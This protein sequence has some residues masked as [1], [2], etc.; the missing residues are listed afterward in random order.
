MLPL[1]DGARQAPMVRSPPV[2]LTCPELN[3]P[4]GSP[5]G[6]PSCPPH[7]S[8]RLP[9]KSSVKV[10]CQP[11]RS[12]RGIATPEVPVGGGAPGA[13][14]AAEPDPLGAGI[15]SP[16][17]S[18]LAAATGAGAACGVGT[19][20]TMILNTTPSRP[21]TSSV[22]AT[23]PMTFPTD[24]RVGSG[25][26]GTGGT[27]TCGTI[28]LAGGGW[29]RPTGAYGW[30]GWAGWSGRGGWKGWARPTGAGCCGSGRRGYMHFLAGGDQ[31]GTP[32]A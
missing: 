28:R 30:G 8:V 25:G 17:A 24:R 27:P 26:S 31:R 6:C 22:V 21:R 12:P 18:L 32:P 9:V 1:G 13:G 2:A 11:G 15:G 10:W 3:Q 5:R 7:W 16:L 4:P 29:A 14:A 23:V 20:R 19:G